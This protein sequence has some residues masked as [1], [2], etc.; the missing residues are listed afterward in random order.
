MRAFLNWA[1]REDIDL[2]GLLIAGI[3]LVLYWR[4]GANICELIR[5]LMP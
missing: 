4:L 5:G 1:Y 2:P 3:I